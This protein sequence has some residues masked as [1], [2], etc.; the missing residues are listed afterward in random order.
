MKQGFKKQLSALLALLMCLMP[1]FSFAEEAQREIAPG[2]MQRVLTREAIAAGREVYGD[3]GLRFDSL[4]DKDM[5]SEERE[6]FKAVMDLFS[7]GSVTFNLALT[8]EGGFGKVGIAMQGQ[9]VADVSLNLTE[10]RALIATSLAPTKAFEVKYDD[11]AE[12]L[13]M[14]DIDWKLVGEMAQTE[15]TRYGAVVM[16]WLAGVPAPLESGAQPATATRDAAAASSTLTITEEKFCELVV[17]MLEEARHDAILE[18]FSNPPKDKTWSEAIDE[19]IAEA[20]DEFDGD[21]ALKVELMLGEMHELIALYVSDGEDQLILESKTDADDVQIRLAL[22]DDDKSLFDMTMVVSAQLGETYK[23]DI[24]M[25]M[26][27]NDDGDSMD[28]SLKMQSEAKIE[29]DVETVNYTGKLLQTL[30]ETYKH[31]DADPTVIKTETTSDITGKSVTERKGE[32]FTSATEIGLV[33]NMVTNHTEMSMGFSEY[34]NVASRAYA[35]QDLS[36]L[37]VLDLLSL[38]G[39]SGMAALAEVE[40]GLMLAFAK[41]MSLLP[42]DA[43]TTVMRLAQDM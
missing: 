27:A 10:D 7:A 23:D 15:I 11:V 30:V 24:A 40:S 26:T 43:L 31:E 34:M 3:F 21:S 12:L 2:T 39:E 29:G 33:M 28:M 41:A 22:M 4:N 9:S 35:P 1:V 16:D 13:G 32:D 38:D 8:P 42:Q 36:G 5:D 37:E 14:K 20:K 6:V 19:M 17:A 25:T 18:S